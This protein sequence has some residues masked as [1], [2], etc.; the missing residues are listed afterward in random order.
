MEPDTLARTPLSPARFGLCRMR[1]LSNED[2]VE[3][4]LWTG[5]GARG[6]D[7]SQSEAVDILVRAKPSRQRT[8]P[9]RSREMP[10]SPRSSWE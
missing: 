3:G 7:A 6:R 8:L 2:S 9:Q 10:N 5:R 1:A 4:G